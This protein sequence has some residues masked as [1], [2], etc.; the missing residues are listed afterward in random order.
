LLLEAID[1]VDYQQGVKRLKNENIYGSP[2]TVRVYDPGRVK[3]FGLQD[4]GETGGPIQFSVD[5][6]EAGDGDVDV[7]YD[8]RQ[9]PTRV[10][11]SGQLHQVSFMPEGPG[12]YSI[13]VEFAN[14]DV[15]GSPFTVEIANPA[16]VAVY[17]DGL[18]K[19]IA[20]Y[21]SRKGVK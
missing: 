21:R 2:F 13:E 19:V 16:V 14:M 1:K 4:C 18:E 9:M 5:T 11:R 15:P 8:G 3:V 6:T 12:V 20:R 17:G 7:I 10:S